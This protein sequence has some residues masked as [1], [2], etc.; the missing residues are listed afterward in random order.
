[1]R[2]RT[3]LPFTLA[4]L[5]LISPLL[6]ACE[7]KRDN[8][9]NTTPTVQIDKGDEVDQLLDELNNALKNIDTMDDVK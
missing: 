2:L 5:L 1:M 8:K 6:T 4:A 7:S 9:L 3:F